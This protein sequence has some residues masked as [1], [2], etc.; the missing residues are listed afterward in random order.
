MMNE[1]IRSQ[2][3]LSNPFKFK[4]I[5]PMK[6]LEG[7]S[8][9]GPSVVMASP[10]TCERQ[11]SSVSLY[12]SLRHISLPPHVMS[13]INLTYS[14]PFLCRYAAKWFEPRFAGTLGG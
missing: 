13:P 4:H 12:I 7:F 6:G 14:V 3:S 10:G 1:H 5:L 9:T 11:S 2:F 8:D